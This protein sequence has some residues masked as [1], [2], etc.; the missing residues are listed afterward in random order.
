MGRLACILSL[1]GV[2]ALSGCA[3]KPHDLVGLEEAIAGEWGHDWKYLHSPGP[4]REYI[5]LNP[6]RT[7]AMQVKRSGSVLNSNSYVIEHWKIENDTLVCDFM[8]P[9]FTTPVPGR[10]D[11]VKDTLWFEHRFALLWISPDSLITHE[12]CRLEKSNC[13][14]VVT[15]E[16]TQSLEE[17]MAPD[18]AYT[19]QEGD[20]KR[21]RQK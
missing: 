5:R 21:P 11:Y 19:P 12:Q 13:D 20:V 2:I 1:I 10:E 3:E 6:D 18:S 14:G 8:S 7:G 9:G 16:R 4:D 17:V 15:W